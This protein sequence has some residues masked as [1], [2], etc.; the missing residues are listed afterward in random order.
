MPRGT[1]K[2]V[3][4]RQPFSNCRLSSRSRPLRLHIS[5]LN[6]KHDQSGISPPQDPALRSMR[7]AL[8][9]GMCPT[10][11]QGV[12]QLSSPVAIYGRGH[13]GRL[14]D[15]QLPPPDEAAMQALVDAAVA[16]SDQRG[17]EPDEV[18]EIKAG[19]AFAPPAW[20]IGCL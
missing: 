3:L 13:N 17:V 7:S 4:P 18:R 8:Q 20:S 5:S 1:R 16:A 2:G 14:F 11:C 6:R 10:A 12:V 15:L 9:D 19:R